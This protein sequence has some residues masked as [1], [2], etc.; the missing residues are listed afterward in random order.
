MSRVVV[1]DRGMDGGW[2]AGGSSPHWFLVNNQAGNKNYMYPFIIHDAR[3]RW[4]VRSEPT[5]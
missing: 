4:I 5:T 3:R 2:S 1:A